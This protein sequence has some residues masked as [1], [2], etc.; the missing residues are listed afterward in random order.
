MYVF[1]PFEPPYGLLSIYAVV[2]FS[3]SGELYRSVAEFVYLKVSRLPSKEEKMNVIS[4]VNP[5]TFFDRLETEEFDFWHAEMRK[6]LHKAADF[7]IS[8]VKDIKKYKGIK[9]SF[10]NDSSLASY[11]TYKV[12][13]Q[14]PPMML[15]KR[16]IDGVRKRLSAKYFNDIPGDPTLYELEKYAT[17][18]TSNVKDD[19]PA[20]EHVDHLVDFL[21]YELKKRNSI[22]EYKRNLS[23]FKQSLF[24]TLMDVTMKTT[25]L[26]PEARRQARRQQLSQKTVGE[27]DNEV[28]ETYKRY[29]KGDIPTAVTERLTVSLPINPVTSYSPPPDRIVEITDEHELSPYNSRNFVTGFKT[30]KTPMHFVIG[31]LA[32][33]IGY[34]GVDLYLVPSK[35]LVSMFDEYVGQNLWNIEKKYLTIGMQSTFKQHSVLGLLLK[36]TGSEIIQFKS[37]N[38]LL[39]IGDDF[40]GE[41]FV[42]R[43]LESLRGEEYP[44]DKKYASAFDNVFYRE[45]LTTR[46]Q[47]EFTVMSLFKTL[48]LD[49]LLELYKFPKATESA[50]PV[51]DVKV[52]KQLF[53]T[54][55]DDMI[56]VAYTLIHPQMI[57]MDSLTDKDLTEYVVMAQKM[58]LENNLSEDVATVVMN[59]F[60][61]FFNKHRDNLKDQSE[62]GFA[63]KVLSSNDHSSAD[64]IESV[65]AVAKRHRVAYWYRFLTRVGN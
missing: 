19:D 26:P 39:G 61:E 7:L 30:Y 13:Q 48:N 43:M 38:R 25:D 24:N 31:D 27:I 52:I 18:L 34:K 56:N 63:A 33:K 1:N 55:T 11:L 4:S 40:S 12:N 16:I 54:V 20:L 9:F 5:P 47:D 46:L 50:R 3:V 36:T 49:Q 32:T 37:S 57:A 59:F 28:E 45:W 22:E 60:A 2:P 29:L 42:G 64:S 53:P 21:K 58:Y 41:N 23:Q 44:D 65:F 8:Q 62:F 51:R 6:N 10:P 14:K 17:N 35:Q 15:V